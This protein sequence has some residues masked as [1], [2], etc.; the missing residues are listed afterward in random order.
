[1][2]F[3]IQTSSFL[4]SY[5]P[6]LYLCIKVRLIQR[7]IDCI[8]DWLTAW[9]IKVKDGCKTCLLYRFHSLKQHQSQKWRT[10]IYNQLV[11]HNREK[12]EKKIFKFCNNNIPKVFA[13][14]SSDPPPPIP[15][16][17]PYVHVN[18]LFI[19]ANQLNMFW[20]CKNKVHLML[21][22]NKIKYRYGNAS[23]QTKMAQKFMN[24][25][26]IIRKI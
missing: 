3:T 22:N 4:K 14:Q 1:M 23:S 13:S 5:T 2:I 15:P 17:P 25:L 19:F 16:L 9:L 10:V 21:E 18:V 7:Q 11:F 24:L 6:D 12:K 26:L 8:S 20:W